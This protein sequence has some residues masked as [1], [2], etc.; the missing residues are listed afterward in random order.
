MPQCTICG[1]HVS[2]SDYSLGGRF[3]CTKIYVCDSPEC[4]REA[5]E[6]ERDADR[7]DD[8]RARYEAGEDNY[9]RYR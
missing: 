6:N 4:N 2:Q 1:D 7:E 9:D 8:D 5:D 3:G